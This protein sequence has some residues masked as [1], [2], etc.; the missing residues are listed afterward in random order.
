MTMKPEILVIAIP[1]LNSRNNPK[2]CRARR[3]T[4][5]LAPTMAK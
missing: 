3:M 1:G 2:H 4:C 5:P